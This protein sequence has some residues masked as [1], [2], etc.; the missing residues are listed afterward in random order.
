M[1]AAKPWCVDFRLYMLDQHFTTNF[2]AT[3][4]EATEH[5][6]ITNCN[7]KSMVYALR[8]YVDHQKSLFTERLRIVLAIKTIE[9]ERR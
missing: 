2:Y 7:D 9:L 8:P 6:G 3:R 1:L 5:M 4:H